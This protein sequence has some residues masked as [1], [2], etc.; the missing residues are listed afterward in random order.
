MYL[1]HVY[2]SL[3]MYFGVNKWYELLKV[4]ISNIFTEFNDLRK[5]NCLR[6][7]VSLTFKN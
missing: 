3:S 7:I 6:K 5:I 2:V 4:L 1:Y